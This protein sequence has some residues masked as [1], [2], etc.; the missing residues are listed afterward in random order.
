[1]PLRHEKALPICLHSQAKHRG[2]TYAAEFLQGTRTFGKAE[3]G[4]RA[5]LP[6]AFVRKNSRESVDKTAGIFYTSNEGKGTR[7]FTYKSSGENVTG[8]VSFYV[9]DK[10][11]NPQS[12][13]RY[14]CGLTFTLIG[15]KPGK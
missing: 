2:K 15:S 8:T 4:R 5:L 9:S 3:R 12:G 14:Q 10:I 1:L 7:V 6:A 11:T 13:E